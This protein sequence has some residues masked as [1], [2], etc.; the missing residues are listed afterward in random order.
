[1]ADEELQSLKGQVQAEIDRLAP[2]L[3]A[4]S[5]F[6]HANP[7]IAYEE[8]Q[9]AELFAAVLEQHGF[10]VNRGVAGLATAFTGL[11]GSG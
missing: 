5:G 1:M 6:L 11:A 2:D 7:E 10:T 9:A 8:R 4:V 3:L